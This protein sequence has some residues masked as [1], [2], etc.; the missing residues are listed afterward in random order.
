MSP[1]SAPTPVSRHLPSFDR[2]APAAE[3][4]CD[5]WVVAGRHAL[6]LASEQGVRDS[7][8]WYEVQSARWNGEDRSL[9][10]AWVDPQRAAWK[11]HTVTE[12]PADFMRAMT[13]AVDHSMV[14]HKQIVVENGTKVVAQIR[15]REDGHLF[16]ILTADGPLSREGQAQADAL[17]RRLREGV[18]LD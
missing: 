2:S 5:Q 7:G 16:S 14:M 10:I 4:E 15:R 3:V 13:E 11:L 12:D 9:R 17:E 18:G 6:I 8:M 1:L